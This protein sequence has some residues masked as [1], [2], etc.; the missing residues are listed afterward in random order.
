M[1]ITSVAS[2]GN[3]RGIGLASE[4]I[5]PVAA[6]PART[7]RSFM[8]YLT[9]ALGDVDRLHR[10]ASASAIDLVLGNE[11]YLHNTLLAYSRASLALQLTIEVRNR[12]VESYQD[13]MRMQ[14]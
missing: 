2:L 11:Q 5:Q 10:E 14:M 8:E 9:S 4:L 13:I 12:L 6:E 3:T 7:E 1:D